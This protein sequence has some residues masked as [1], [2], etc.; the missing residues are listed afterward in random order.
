MTL[1]EEPLCPIN[2]KPAS[3]TEADGVS[4]ATHHKTPDFWV[5]TAHL[6]YGPELTARHGVNELLLISSNKRKGIPTWATPSC[7]FSS[8]DSCF[9][10]DLFWTYTS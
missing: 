5:L 8:W 9:A 2:G 1:A 3:P 10:N 7:F 6:N 4:Q